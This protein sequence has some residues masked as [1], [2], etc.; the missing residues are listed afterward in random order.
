MIRRLLPLATALALVALPAT[1]EADSVISVKAGELRIVNDDPGV[2]NEFTIELSGDRI[3][4]SEPKDPQGMQGGTEAGCSQTR[5]SGTVATQISCPRSAVQ[6]VL[7]EAGPAE[8]LVVFTVPGLPFSVAGGTGADNVKSFDGADDLS[9]EQG[10]DTLASGAGDDILNGDEGNDALDAGDGNDKLTG[11]TGTDS[12]VAGGGDDT[13]FAADGLAEKVDCG[14][15]ADTVTADTQDEL[16]G[17][18]TV[19][20]QNIT[21]VTDEQTGDDKTKPKIQVGGSSSQKAG[22]SVRFVATCSEKGLVQAVA[23]VDVRGINSAMKKAEKKVGVAGGGVALNL[24]FGKR[25]MRDIRTDL[26]KKRRVRVRVTVSCVDAA[27]NTSRARHF[28]I[29]LRR[30]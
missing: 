14:D 20:R 4:I 22:R 5:F 9:G 27:G 17:C 26:R 8:D 1:A 28:W 21:G 23:Y 7:L 25:Q 24:G 19:S 29:K 16:I 3:L 13:I 30:R 12:F 2:A 6:T 10:N 18:E 15:G 11:G